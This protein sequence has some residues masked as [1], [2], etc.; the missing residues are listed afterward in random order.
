MTSL[1]T[2]KNLHEIPKMECAD[3]DCRNDHQS[4]ARYWEWRIQILSNPKWCRMTIEWLGIGR[5]ANKYNKS[6][7]KCLQPKTIHQQ[8]ECRSEQGF[9]LKVIEL[10][11]DLLALEIHTNIHICRAS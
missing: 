10:V 2:I 11:K 6:T 4:K 7:T 8:F 3:N 9:L 5:K 1:L